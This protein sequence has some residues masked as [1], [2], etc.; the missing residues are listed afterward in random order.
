MKYL[1][2]EVDDALEI[3]EQTEIE[4][5]EH[6]PH[7]RL[8]DGLRAAPFWHDVACVQSA[9]SGR[10]WRGKI[11]PMDVCSLN[12]RETLGSFGGMPALGQSC[13]LGHQVEDTG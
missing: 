8:I 7:F 3:S 6:R 4:H 1:G 9:R 11:A 5:P 10:L 2:I 12:P 13:E